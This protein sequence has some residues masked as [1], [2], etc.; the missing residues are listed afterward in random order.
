MEFQK[1]FGPEP[2]QLDWYGIINFTL[3]VFLDCKWHKYKY[4]IHI[5]E[6]DEHAV[7]RSV[8]PEP[9]KP[10]NK[11]KDDKTEKPSEPNPTEEPPPEGETP[12]KKY[13]ELQKR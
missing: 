12:K 4:S 6:K 1:I 11:P 13:G 9:E 2:K 10:E 8:T 5:S 7:W 3:A